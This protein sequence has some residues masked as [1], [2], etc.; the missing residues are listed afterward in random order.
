VARTRM[1]SVPPRVSSSRT[2]GRD[3][4]QQ[5]SPALLVFERRTTREP[6]SPT[7][8][9]RAPGHIGAQRPAQAAQSAKHRQQSVTCPSGPI[10]LGRA[11]GADTIRGTA[12]KHERTTRGAAARGM[13]A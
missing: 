5:V 13:Q 8:L 2:S 12:M 3:A 11:A 1:S 6:G 10:L 4:L 7:C 9:Q